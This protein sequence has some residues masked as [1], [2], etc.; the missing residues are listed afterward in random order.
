M[1]TSLSKNFAVTRD[2]IIAMALRKIGANDAADVIPATELSAAA[3][4]LNT[5]VKEWTGEGL[6]LWLRRTC[7]LFLQSGQQRY[8]VGSGTTAF[9]V[10]Q[11]SIYYG[12]LTTALTTASTTLVVTTWYDY[13]DK[14]VSTNLGTGYAAIR[15]DSGVMDFC[16]ITASSATGATFSG[17]PVDS[18]AAIGAKVYAFTTTSMITRPVR[19]LSA[20]RLN[21]NGNTAEISLIGRAD[22]DLL[23]QKNS[24]GNPTQMHFDPQLDAAQLL[25]WPVANSTDTNQIV[26]TL[27]FYPDDFDAAAN[28][29][30]FPI[31]WANALVWNLAMEMSFE[32]GTDVRTRTQVAQIAISKKNILFDTADRENASVTFA[33]SQ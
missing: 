10:N 29:P 4:S 27:E 7:V 13:Q 31:E 17:T 21:N 25:V 14:V 32:Y 18:A 24:S 19:V 15:L 20:T 1:A 3:L 12:T 8:K 26:M 16:P 2:D 23:S 6:A 33:V 5:L 30:E 22:Y 11:D 28:N 9:C